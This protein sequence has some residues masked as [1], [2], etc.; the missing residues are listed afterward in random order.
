MPLVTVDSTGH[1]R[2]FAL[3]IAPTGYL[4]CDGS[5]LNRAAY[6]SLFSVIGTAFNVGGESTSEFRLPDLRGKAR[7]GSGQ[8]TG[9]G[10][11]NRVHGTY[12]ASASYENHPLAVTEIPGHTHSGSTSPGGDSHSHSGGTTGNVDLAHSHYYR[13]NT[14]RNNAHNCNSYKIA[15]TVTR[16]TYSISPATLN[17]YHPVSLTTQSGT[18]NHTTYTTNPGV[19]L[20]AGDG[21][22]HNNMM[23]SAVALFCIKY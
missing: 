6:A 20:N 11:T 23:P 3:D 19:G 22:G 2:A 12:M 18:H 8:D 4:A 14:L 15:L 16:S 17:H 21:N 13:A 1:I 7:M 10:L 9:R 5:L